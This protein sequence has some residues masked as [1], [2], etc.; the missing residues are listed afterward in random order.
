VTNSLPLGRP[1]PLTIA[2]INCVAYLKADA[3]EVLRY[4]RTSSVPI[5]AL[6]IRAKLLVLRVLADAAVCDSTHIHE[7]LETNLEDVRVLKAN[8]REIRMEYNKR[9]RKEKETVVRCAI[10]NRNLH[11]RMPLDPTPARLKRAV[12][13]SKRVTKGIPL[14]CP[15]F[16]TSSHC[17]S[18]PNTEGRRIASCPCCSVPGFGQHFAL[19]E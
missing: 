17:K 6:S 12:Q 9:K 8:Q 18:R 7:T 16:L 1:L 13:A 11:S 5:G 15:T 14:G 10:F 19:E 4:T 2:T 3:D